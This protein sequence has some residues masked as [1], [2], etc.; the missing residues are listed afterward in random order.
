MAP[1]HSLIAHYCSKADGSLLP[2]FGALAVSDAFVV[3]YS[4]RRADPRNL[5][6]R[7]ANLIDAKS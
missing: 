2:P 3:H 6:V 7:T 5:D 1:R 4:P